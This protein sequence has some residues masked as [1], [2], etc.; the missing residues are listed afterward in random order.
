M[1]PTLTRVGFHWRATMQHD[2]VPNWD[3]WLREI[4]E[5][6]IGTLF[7]GHDSSGMRN[8]NPLTGRLDP[9][10]IPANAGRASRA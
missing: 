3:M 4:E 9:N 5:L 1:A 10:G 8:Y 7:I 6:G 2:N